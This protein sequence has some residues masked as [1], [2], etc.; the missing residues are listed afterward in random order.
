MGEDGSR[1]RRL[2]WI[3]SVSVATRL[4]VAVVLV[5]IVS[6]TV[7]TI[8]GVNTGRGLSDTIVSERLDALRTTGAAEVATEVTSL[9]RAAQTIAASPQTAAELAEFVDGYSALAA[10]PRPGLVSDA[11]DLVDQYDEEF[12][13]PLQ[14]AGL[15][16]ARRDLIDTDNVAAL[17]LQTS[18]SLVDEPADAPRD[19]DDARD[20]SEWTETHRRVHPTLRTAADRLDLVDLLL[21][22]PGADTIVYSVSKHPDLGTSL[23]IGPFSGSVIA[24]AVESVRAD[25]AA[26]TVVTDV[27]TYL[28]AGL[29]PVGAVAAP[30]TDD[31]QLIGIVVLVYSTERFTDLLT[32]DE[33]WDSAG[34]PPTGETFMIAGDGT[35]RSDPRTF[36]EDPREH[37]SA[38][39]QTG[40]IDEDG[41]VRIRRSGT[42]VLTEA[43]IG[44]TLNAAQDGDEE[45]AIRTTVVGEQAYS[46]TQPVPVDGVEWYVV[47]EVDADVIRQPLQDFGNRLIIGAAILVVITAFAAVAWSSAMMSSIR[48]M[49]ERLRTWRTSTGPIDVP[50]RSPVE[51]ERLA[52]SFSEMARSLKSQRAELTAARDRRTK[53]LRSM[54]PAQVADRVLSGELEAAEEIPKV[55]VAVIVVA[56]LGDLVRLDRDG[57]DR[58]LLDRLTAELDDIGGRHGLERIKI[59]G[60][61]YFAV[62]GH[63]RPY[64][65]HA[66]RVLSFA[67]DAQDAVREHGTATDGG[68]D[69]VIGIHTGPVNVG[70]TRETGLVY[71]VWGPSV[72]LAH[73]LARSGRRGQILV[74]GTT[75]VLLPETVTTEPIDGDRSVEH[76]V[77]VVSAET[78]G[79][80]V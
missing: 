55:T 29:V 74:S 13:E 59:V 20:G 48:E 30:V 24:D 31:D 3:G 66:P 19:R 70:M 35:M 62:C 50:E 23:D 76:E 43:A 17:Q 63:S 2:K 32:A 67:A 64:I 9:E 4:A 73:D 61:A 22:E 25:P 57:A 42:T 36:I 75:R 14:A 26:G 15:D 68:L 72:T 40:S 41:R 71:D 80:T 51:I 69:V 27:S 12:I 1:P 6:L 56:G 78:V 10:D 53:L 38:A 54:L 79:G 77:F 11:E 58:E 16:V 60:D 39:E 28:P 5:S 44:E 18:Y 49:S 21:V 65:D 33:D 45:V 47:S 37:L 7:A 8:V 46:T 52:A 34:F